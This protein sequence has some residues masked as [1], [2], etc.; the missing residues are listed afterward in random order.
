MSIILSIRMITRI[1]FLII[2]KKICFFHSLEIYLKNQMSI[3]RKKLSQPI[4]VWYLSLILNRIVWLS[5]KLMISENKLCLEIMNNMQQFILE[6]LLSRFYMIEAFKRQ[7]ILFH[8]QEDSFNCLWAQLGLLSD[9]IINF[10]FLFSWPIKFTNFRAKKIF[11]L[12]K[13]N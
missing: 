13:N 9:P 6:D 7:M 4:K 8:I 3:L 5:K 11:R 1:L 12:M 10:A 2:S